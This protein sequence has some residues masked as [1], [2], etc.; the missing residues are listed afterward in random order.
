MPTHLQKLISDAILHQPV[1][2]SQP[3]PNLLQG[4]T[5]NGEKYSLKQ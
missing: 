2:D 4:C 5:T 1:L 3:R